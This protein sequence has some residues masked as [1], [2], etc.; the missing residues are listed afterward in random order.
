MSTG[1]LYERTKSTIVYNELLLIPPH[2]PLL[3]K[4]PDHRL[5]TNQLFLGISHQD[6]WHD[7]VPETESA[8]L[9][10]HTYILTCY[11]DSLRF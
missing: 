9:S 7:G 8:S 5:Q 4:F 2:P 1:L 10:I 3:L 11:L 6:D